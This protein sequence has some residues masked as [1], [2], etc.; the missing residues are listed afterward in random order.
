MEYVGRTNNNGRWEWKFID[1]D[2]YQQKE[3]TDTDKLVRL[4]N[5]VHQIKRDILKRHTSAEQPNPVFDKNIPLSCDM[6]V[7]GELGPGAAIRGFMTGSI[8]GGWFD[9]RFAKQL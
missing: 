8:H 9:H 3:M 7:S 5:I 4:T 1:P 6:F 2:G